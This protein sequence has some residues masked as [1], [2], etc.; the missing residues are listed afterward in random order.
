MP[1]QRHGISAPHSDTAAGRLGRAQQLGVGTT[2]TAELDWPKAYSTLG[3]VTLSHD[4][5]GTTFPKQPLPGDSLGL[6]LLLG[7]RVTAFAPPGLERVSHLFSLLYTPFSLTTSFFLF[8]LFQLSPLS[9]LRWGV[10]NWLGWSW[11]ATMPHSEIWSSWNCLYI[12]DTS[13]SIPS[14]QG[15]LSL[16]LQCSNI[17]CIFTIH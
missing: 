12:A 1:A 11:T 14:V 9:H 2:T 7:G 8:L 10:S 3:N 4:N 16:D 5:W 17:P 13:S 6:S 15:L